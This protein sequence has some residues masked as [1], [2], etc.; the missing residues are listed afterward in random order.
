MNDPRQLFGK[1]AFLLQ[2]LSLF[3]PQERPAGRVDLD[4]RRNPFDNLNAQPIRKFL[5]DDRLLDP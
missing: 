4:R 3:I 1:I 2:D 5:P